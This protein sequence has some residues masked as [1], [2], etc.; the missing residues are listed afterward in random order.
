[1]RPFGPSRPLKEMP[2]VTDSKADT[3]TFNDPKYGQRRTRFDG[4]A[5]VARFAGWWN[6][7]LQLALRSWAAA[8]VDTMQPRENQGLAE[9]ILAPGGSLISEFVIPTPP[10]PQSFSNSE[11]YSSSESHPPRNFPGPVSCSR[12]RSTAELSAGSAAGCDPEG[13]WEQ[14]HADT[15]KLCHPTP[16]ESSAGQ[17][18]SLSQGSEL[19]PHEKKGVGDAQDRQAHADGWEV[20]GLQ[21]GLENEVSPSDI[22]A[23]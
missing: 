12:R 9:Q 17:T 23:A 20:E 1:M 4:A 3:V 16:S 15:R 8:G 10:T 7:F 22:L 11:S 2:E 6:A 19:P 5:V 21:E 13:V 14:P 18:A